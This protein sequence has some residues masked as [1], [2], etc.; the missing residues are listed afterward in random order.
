MADTPNVDS[1]INTLGQQLS[2]Y[3]SAQNI[4]NPLMI[5]IHTGGAWVAEKLHNQLQLS[6]PLGT[7]NISFYRDDFTSIG[8][9]PQV[10]PSELPASVENQ[11]IILV[12]D[13]LHTGRTI[14]AALNEVFDYGRPQ[15]VTLAVLIERDHREL[16]ICAQVVGQRLTLNPG[17][18]IKLT[19]Q[20]NQLR[21]VTLKR[22]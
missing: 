18:N 1:L 19:Q 8:L 17:E 13:V 16:P 21:L 9:H 12:D 22:A 11:D 20:N 2:T 7:L 14:R 3:L 6:Q 10:K 15:S 4:T 5:G